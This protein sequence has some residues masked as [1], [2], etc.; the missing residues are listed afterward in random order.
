MSEQYTTRTTP[1]PQWDMSSDCANKRDNV[2]IENAQV[3]AVEIA[4]APINIF[5][6]MGV[7]NQGSTIDLIGTGYALSSGTPSRI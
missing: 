6:L 5:P 3:E 7:H 2:L 4:G 1:L